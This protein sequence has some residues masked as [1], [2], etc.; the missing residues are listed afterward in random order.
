MNKFL[1]AAVLTG[2]TLL[3]CQSNSSPNTQTSSETNYTT[4]ATSVAMAALQAWSTQGN[5][6]SALIESIQGVTNVSTD[7][8]IGGVGSL[9]ALAQNTLKPSQ[10]NELGSLVPGYEAL[11]NS[12]LTSMITTSSAVDS[13]FSSLGMD[14]SMV[15]SFSP[16]IIE[17]LK[18]QGASSSL[19]SSLG[20]IWQ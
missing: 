8:A 16:I 17:S 19:L 11:E 7:Q 20:A 14:T 3:G 13:T 15:N 18:S 5:L 2:T 4:I 9:L 1:I 12:G 6:D 10:N